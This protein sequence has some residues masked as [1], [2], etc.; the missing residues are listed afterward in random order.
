[1]NT[2]INVR[3]IHVICAFCLFFLGCSEGYDISQNPKDMIYKLYVVTNKVPANEAQ[4]IALFNDF[5]GIYHEH[6]VKVIGVWVNMEN[7]YEVYFMTAFNDNDHYNSFLESTKE[8][9]DYQKMAKILEDER[10]D[11]KAV[12]LRMSVDL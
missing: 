1:M 7:P 2:S 11:I 3:L 6:D 12:N 10:E 8:D 9:E 5:K 4:G